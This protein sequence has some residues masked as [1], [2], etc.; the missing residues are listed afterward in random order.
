[1]KAGEIAL[2]LR[3]VG[4]SESGINNIDLMVHGGEIVGLAGL[5]GAGRTELAKT[6]FGLTPADQ[7]EIL[8]GGQPAT[9]TNPELAIR[10]GI[11]YLPEDRRK[12]GVI[13]ELSI[14]D[15]IT[16]ASSTKTVGHQLSGIDFHAERE[17]A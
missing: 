17:I 14:G 1:A 15:N 5:V 2:E 6:I 12:H 16:L 3:K 9:I 7:G 11:A 13:G 8:V 4:C 10:Y